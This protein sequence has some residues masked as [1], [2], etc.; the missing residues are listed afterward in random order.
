MSDVAILHD[1]EARLALTAGVDIV[2]NT[3]K[4]T[5]GPS[6]RNVAHQGQLGRPKITHDGVSVARDIQLRNGFLQT[7]AAIVTEACR[8]TN[9]AAGDGTTTA[10]VLTQ[11]L[12]HEAQRLVA[13]GADPMRLR[14]GLAAAV[15]GVDRAVREQ[16]RPITTLQ[17][18]AWV[19]GLAAHDAGFGE[20]IAGIF[21][22]YGPE[23]AVTVELGRGLST[24]AHTV[25]GMRLERGLASLQLATATA[26]RRAELEDCDV[27][28]TDRE[29]EGV[30]P[31]LPFL[32]A[33]VAGGGQRLLVVA[34]TIGG[35]ALATLVENHRLGR[36][37]VIA[38]RAPVF[39]ERQRAMLEDLAI[40]TGASLVAH[41]SG[42]PW[43]SVPVSVLG[44]AARVRSDTRET[45][46]MGGAGEPPAIAE[47][48][49]LLWL[50]R[51]RAKN[52]FDREK[53]EERIRN[54]SGAVSEIHV[55][56]P[57]DAEREEA[58]QRVE[59]AVA[60]TR[61]ALE[62]GIVAGGG[63]ALARAAAGL[64]APPD[65]HSDEAD[66]WEV[67]RRALPA[68]VATIARNAGYDGAVVA[69]AVAHAVATGDPPQAFDVTSGAYVDPLTAG[70]VDPVAVVRA[71]LRYAAS[72][73]IMIITSN[74]VVADAES[75]GPWVRGLRRR[76]ARDAGILLDG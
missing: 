22:R 43:G 35:E 44:R 54:L 61:A 8:L 11:A 34:K 70:I 41:E 18:T 73:A 49:E 4:C 21:D 72:A 57:T 24:E 7:G 59:D 60:A 67:V 3:V 6:G 75:Y 32:E 52:Q 69:H 28:V 31:I 30:G 9:T 48:M 29:L 68:P 51:E 63:S 19:A 50:Y 45:L 12:T 37:S 23:A 64:T 40:F 55:A 2:A 46:V 20:I 5:M 47:R 65:A 17:E 26:A 58:R 53:L 13:A 33:Y 71:A 39:G 76:L 56:A 25:E 27:L 14:R 1:L 66:G 42:D 15:L 16:A 62:E 10:A 36:M 74:T 38:V